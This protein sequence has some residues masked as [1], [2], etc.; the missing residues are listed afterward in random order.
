[1]VYYILFWLLGLRI[2]PLLIHISCNVLL[3]MRWEGIKK[4][5]IHLKIHKSV[6]RTISEDVK[7]RGKKKKI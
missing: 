4:D 2:Y 7:K 1:M 6:D 5:E 3:Q